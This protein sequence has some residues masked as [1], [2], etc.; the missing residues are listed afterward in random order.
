MV[1]GRTEFSKFTSMPEDKRKLDA[2]SKIISNAIKIGGPVLRNK[3][4]L[5]VIAKIISNEIKVG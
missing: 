3:K 5:E 1:H 2:I 4:K